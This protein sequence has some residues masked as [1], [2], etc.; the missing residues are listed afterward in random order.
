MHKQVHAANL[1]V[2]HAAT[3][4]HVLETQVQKA[5]ALSSSLRCA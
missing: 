2:Q 4:S 3:V 5:A 1:L